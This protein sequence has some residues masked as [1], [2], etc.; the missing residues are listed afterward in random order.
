[1]TIL[2][3][4]AKARYCLREWRQALGGVSVA[5]LLTGGAAAPVLAAD[6]GGGSLTGA[7]LKDAPVVQTW[8]GFYV[9]VNGGYG[10]S[11]SKAK[12]FSAADDFGTIATSPL[13]AFD[14]KGEFGGGQIGYNLQRSHFVFGVEADIQGSGIH[15]SGKAVA[16]ADNGDVIA[17]ANGKRD[18]DWFGTVRGR[19]GYTIDRQLIYVTGGLAFG[20]VKKSSLTADDR[21]DGGTL[22]TF[23]GGD[24][25]KTGFVLGGGIEYAINPSWSLKGEYQYINLGTTKGA[26]SVSDKVDGGNSASAGFSAQDRY[27]TVRLGLNYHVLPGYEPLTELDGGSLKDASLK[28]VTA[29]TGY[30]WTGYYM[31]THTGYAWGSSNWAASSGGAVIDRGTMGMQ[32][33]YDGFNQG[34]SWFNGLQFGYN[35]MLQNRVVIGAQADITSAAFPNYHFNTIGNTINVEGGAKTY[36]DNVSVSG[37]VRGRLG[38][39]PGNSLFYVTGGLAWSS[40]KYSL[41]DIASGTTDS[42]FQQRLGYVV[43]GGVEAPLIPSWTVN[44]EYLYTGYG[45]RSIGFPANGQRFTSDLSENQIRVGVNYHFG[46]AGSEK[47][48]PN[49]AGFLFDSDSVNIHAQATGVWQGYPKF[50][51]TPNSIFPGTLGFS[52]RGEAREIGDMTLFAGFKLWKG[53]EFWVLPEIDQGIGLNGSIGISAYPDG[54]AFKIGSSQPYAKINRAFVRQTIDLGGETVNVAPD[55][56]QFA[57]T[58]TSNRLVLTA[59]RL[60]PLDM[61]DKNQYTG[62]PKSQFLNWGLMYGLPFDWGGDAWGYGWGAVS[63]LYYDRYAFRFGWFDTE[64][65][66]ISNA[67]PAH[68][69]FGDDPTFGQVNLMWELEEKHQLWGQ[70]GKVALNVNYIAFRGGTYKAAIAAFNNPSPSPALLACEQIPGAP[71]GTIAPETSCVRNYTRK[72]DTH[73]NIEQ[74]ITPDIGVFSRIG[75]HPGYIEALAITDTNF[76]ASGGVSV[77]GTSWGRPDDTIG[78]GA[79]WNQISKHE[80][81]YLALGGLGSFVGDGQLAHPGAEQVLETYYRYQLSPS[82]SLTAD[83][84]LIANPGM[85]GDRGPVN[86]FAGRFHWQY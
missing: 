42:S 10:W 19:F 51:E 37:T 8:T 35:R 59:G 9:G 14:S 55:L 24:E 36:S 71:P 77:K 15:G 20:G 61:F 43:G 84:Q 30:D 58:T 41:T 29:S 21:Q 26:I 6:L 80:Q 28:D 62:D 32:Q 67:S 1:M 74:A 79:I 85:N 16:N 75:W 86:I 54:E 48:A 38:Y 66:A 69:I 65:S 63:E 46:D 56:M 2:Y 72:V 12:E 53:A 60:Q 64:K 68:P 81:Q 13:M 34:G 44:A 70:P 4:I 52:G 76:F 7:S 83:Y 27:S 78:I 50:H 18:L 25:T 57:G 39:A 45:N 73:I 17:T 11:A 33:S 5:I 49:L 3:H 47:D 22:A 31:G 40:E 82:T 23:G